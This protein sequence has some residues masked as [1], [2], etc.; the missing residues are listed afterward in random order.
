M[1]K[2]K[3][4]DSDNT[5]FVISKLN[6]K[7]YSR[8]THTHTKKYNM[9]LDQYMEKFNLSKMDL[10]CVKLQNKLGFTHQK[11]IEMYGEDEGNRRWNEYISKQ[12]YTNTF[13]YKTQKYGMTLDEFKTY[14]LSRSCSLSN[15]IKRYGEI[16]G[17][18][19]FKDYCKKQAYAGCS[20]EYFKE[21]YGDLMGEQIYTDVCKKKALTLENFILRYGVEDGNKRYMSRMEDRNIFYSRISQDL[22]KSFDIKSLNADNI[23]YAES[24]NGEYGVYDDIHNRYYFYDYVNLNNKKCIEFNGDI[25]HG[26][27]KIYNAEDTPNFHKRKLTCKQMWE[28]DKA[29]IECLKRLRGIETFV[30][31]ESEYKENPD[32][33]ILDCLE[34]LSK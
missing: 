17:Q 12:S 33:V 23:Y 6:G 13:E 24:P 21:K 18:E 26:N 8:I 31:W 28:Y 4:E 10:I 16:K 30:V 3:I 1:L 5:T 25:F 11:C 2:L 19:M 34:F 7:K 15:Y 9:T 20:V 22:F 14:N 29:K 27:P 32:N